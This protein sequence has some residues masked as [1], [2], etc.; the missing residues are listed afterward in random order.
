MADQ[1][2]HS[3]HP[4]VRRLAPIVL[5]AL[6]QVVGT[7]GI[8]VLSGII[9]D[10][11]FGLAHT[12]IP[13]TKMA[14]ASWFL[15]EVSGF[16]VQVSLG[17]AA[18][19]AIAR[20]VPSRFAVWVWVLPLVFFCFGAT[21]V[22]QPAGSRLNYMF[23]DTCKPAEHCFYQILFTLPFLVSIGYA[24]GAAMARLRGRK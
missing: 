7:I 24:S 18:G 1:S 23:G 20:W 2:N 17:L 6:H 9:C 19:F 11:L 4:F 13:S 5:V 16:P 15:T 8:I 3:I 21:L 10:A 22:V 12:L 14:R